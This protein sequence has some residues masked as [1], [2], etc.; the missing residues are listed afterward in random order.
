VK[1]PDGTFTIEGRTY[2]SL[3]NARAYLGCLRK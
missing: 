2:D 1:N 3:A